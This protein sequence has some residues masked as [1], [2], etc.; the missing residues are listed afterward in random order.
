LLSKA[1]S[2]KLSPCYTVDFL[3]ELIY[4]S[5]DQMSQQYDGMLG[6]CPILLMGIT[7]KLAWKLQR[8][9]PVTMNSTTND[10][11]IPFPTCFEGGWNI[12]DL[13]PEDEVPNRIV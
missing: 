4:V 10:L 2:V 6:G 12:D 8:P 5:D 11:V 9:L 1:F 3:A 7:S 13:S